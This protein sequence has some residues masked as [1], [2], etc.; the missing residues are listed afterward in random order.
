[1]PAIPPNPASAIASLKVDPR[2][3]NER[4]D[5]PSEVS[6]NRANT[7]TTRNAEHASAI[8]A[9]RQRVTQEAHQAAELRTSRHQPAS[10]SQTPTI[11]IYV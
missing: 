10:G 5:D 2:A 8:Q 6:R 3:N 7:N 4:Q 1:M 11:D 9:Q